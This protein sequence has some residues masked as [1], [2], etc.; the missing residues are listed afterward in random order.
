MWDET[1]GCPH[2]AHTTNLVPCTLVGAANG[3]GIANGRLADLAPSIL[4]MLD[5]EQPA[6]M[7]GAR[8]QQIT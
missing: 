8:L 7:T 2:T 1:H 5:I 3:V 6:E 4:A